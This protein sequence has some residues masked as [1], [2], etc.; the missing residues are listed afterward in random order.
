MRFLKTI[1][2]ALIIGLLLPSTVFASQEGMSVV[3]DSSKMAVY[4][5][6]TGIENEYGFSDYLQNQWKQVWDNWYYFGDDGISKQNTWANIEGKWYY[7]DQWSV[8]LHDTT[9]PD[10]YQVN[11]DGAWVK[12]GQVVIETV[13]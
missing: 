1:T 5:Y 9:T 10:G 12:D 4:K 11:S 7:F 13:K 8:M 2:V 3:R 6:E